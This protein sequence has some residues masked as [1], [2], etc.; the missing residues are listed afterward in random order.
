MDAAEPSASER[1]DPGTDTG[2][3]LSKVA[4]GQVVDRWTAR[5]PAVIL[6]VLLVGTPVYT[7]LP[8]EAGV[9]VFALGTVTT[10]M[11]HGAVDH[12]VPLR[13][14]S[15]PLGRS[16]SVVAAVY[17]ILGVIVVVGW[18]VAPAVAF[19]T[20][21]LL[22]W[23]HWGQGDVF[24]LRLGGAAHLQSRLE[25]A[26]TVLVRGGLPMAVPLVSFPGEFR[27]VAEATVGLFGV[28]SAT[29]DPIFALSTRTAVATGIA[30]ATLVALSAGLWRV[31]RGAPR[32]G[33]GRDAA[34]L[35]VLWLWFWLVPPVLAIG[36]YFA[37]WHAP[38]HIGR[39][40]LVDAESIAALSAGNARTAIR[41]FLRDAAP[42]TLGGYLVMI[43]VGLAVPAGV[44]T[45]LD[46]LGV[47]LVG[48]AALTLPHVAVVGWL[49]RKQGI[50]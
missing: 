49:D 46:L 35:A 34:E 9:V 25:R 11:A 36:V 44:A 20:F 48:I 3:T 23:L 12:L 29:L 24:A 1:V 7:R 16:L 6:A 4:A 19:V 45:P 41:R 30:A 10:G 47:A 26:L 17:A 39:L 32:D 2:T 38:R 40:V 31:S 43:S 18:W 15:V 27:L 5:N 13:A 28:G 50:W 8:V 37:L 21:V 33:L 22:T 14:A 42:L